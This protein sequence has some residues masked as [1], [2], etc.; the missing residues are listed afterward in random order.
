MILNFL[1]TFLILLLVFGAVW[2]IATMIPLPPNFLKIVQ[3]VLAVV[4]IIVMLGMLLGEVP[5]LR[6]GKL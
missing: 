4:F 1:I 5:Y 3:I 6:L 2:W